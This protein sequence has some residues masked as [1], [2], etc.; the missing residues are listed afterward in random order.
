MTVDVVVVSFVFI[1]I[2]QYLQQKNIFCAPYF[3]LVIV[4]FSPIFLEWPIIG[5]RGR[6]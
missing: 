4:F 1:V 5:F 3:L 6:W 2:Q